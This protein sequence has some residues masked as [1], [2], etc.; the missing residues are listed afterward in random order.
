MRTKEAAMKN[1][2]GAIFRS[3]ALMICVLSVFILGSCSRKVQPSVFSDGRIE[4]CEGDVSLNGGAGEADQK[5]E[6]RSTIE[7]K[8]ASLCDLSFN[9]KNIVHISENTI[10][11]V[12]M[13]DAPE[14]IEVSQGSL[15]LVL[16]KLLAIKDSADLTV[17]T[18]TAALGVRG[19]S[20]FVNVE[21]KN[22]TYLCICNGTL[23]IE[24]KNGENN[25]ELTAPHH[26]AIRYIEKNGAI[27][28]EDAPMLY[29]SDSDVEETAAKIGVD[30][31]WT[32][33]D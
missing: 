9:K 8:T 12:D 31:D 28:I 5:I 11:N 16:K 23:H 4:Y 27:S 24:D 21:N 3:F 7:T 6:D 30:I 10:F 22:S 32:K 20:F 18:P 17:R 2:Y 15:L 29:H 33:A 19:T 13:N 26:R 1:N 25:L 14:T